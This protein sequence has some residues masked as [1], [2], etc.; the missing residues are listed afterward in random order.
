MMASNT[1]AET[2]TDSDTPQTV[3]IRKCLRCQTGFESSWSGERVCPNCKRS[4]AWRQGI[5]S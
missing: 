5:A 4:N 1:A 2:N 3:K